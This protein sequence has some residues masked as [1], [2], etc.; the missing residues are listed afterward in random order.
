M[1]RKGRDMSFKTGKGK[2]FHQL[3]LPHPITGRSTTLNMPRH[4]SEFQGNHMHTK[5]ENLSSNE[6]LEAAVL[7]NMT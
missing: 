7:K 3:E 6:T 2:T 5:A 4:G 1:S